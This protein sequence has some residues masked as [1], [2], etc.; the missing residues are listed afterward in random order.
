MWTI[1]GIDLPPNKIREAIKPEV[2]AIEYVPCDRVTYD[3]SGFEDTFRSIFRKPARTIVCLRHF[4]FAI[5]AKR[6]VLGFEP[7][8]LHMQQTEKLEKLLKIYKR[9]V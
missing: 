3:V 8:K 5:D 6:G 1:L 7:L 2:G 9:Q 4:N